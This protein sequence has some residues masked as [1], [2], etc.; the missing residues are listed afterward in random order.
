MQT[1]VASGRIVDFILL[2]MLVEAAVLLIYRRE[3]GRGPAPVAL[4][5][6]LAAG[7]CLLLALRAALMGAGWQIVAAWLAAALVAHLADLW[8]RLRVPWRIGDS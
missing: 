1:L 5:M 4:V 7:L 3:T 6:M 8:L 2:F